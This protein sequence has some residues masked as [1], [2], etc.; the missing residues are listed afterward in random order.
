MVSS[1]KASCPCI[2]A[3]F[4]LRLHRILSYL[5]LKWLLKAFRH[6]STYTLGSLPTRFCFYFAA[7]VSKYQVKALRVCY[8]LLLTLPCNDPLNTIWID[9]VFFGML[10]ILGDPLPPRKSCSPIYTPPTCPPHDL[11]SH[12]YTVV[13]C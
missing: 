8:I 10:P 4:V 6:S 3:D 13:L 12:V 2:S 7:Q 11:L 5:L 1:T 9:T